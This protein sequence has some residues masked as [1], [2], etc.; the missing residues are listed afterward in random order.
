MSEQTL[1]PSRWTLSGSLQKWTHGKRILALRPQTNKGWAVLLSPSFW[2][3]TRFQKGLP[4]HPKKG[5]IYGDQLCKHVLSPSL[6]RS[7]VVWKQLLELQN[8]KQD[9][10][11]FIPPWNNRPK[12]PVSGMS[13]ET[14]F[15]HVRKQH[16]VCKTPCSLQDFC[17]FCE[18]E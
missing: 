17:P 11:Y 9:I 5:W 8:V 10:H 18:S 4:S 2:T 1:N 16:R 14:V 13:S 12:Q 3:G 6:T 15:V 7:C